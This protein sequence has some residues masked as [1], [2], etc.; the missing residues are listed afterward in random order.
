MTALQMLEVTERLNQEWPET[1]TPIAV[2]IGVNSGPAEDGHLFLSRR[3]CSI[4]W[5]A[6]MWLVQALSGPAGHRI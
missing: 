4:E 5:H 6:G 2:H 1:G 3:W